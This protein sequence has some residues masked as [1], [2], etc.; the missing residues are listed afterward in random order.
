ML[1]RLAASREAPPAINAKLARKV[2]SSLGLAELVPVRLRDGEAEPLGSG[3]LPLH[4]LAQS[5]GWLLVSA[6]RE[7][8]PAGADVVVRPW[9]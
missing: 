6:D 3:Y 5:D 1:K 7:G 2:A 4:V 9:P 8:Y